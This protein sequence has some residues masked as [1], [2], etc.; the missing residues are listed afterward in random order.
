M[1]DGLAVALVERR[2]EV[3]DLAG[4]LAV[5][6]AGRLVAE[7]ERRVVDDRA[8]D[9]DALLLAAGEL[10]RV[11]VGAVGEAD[12]LERRIDVLLALGAREAA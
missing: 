12:E 5:E 1:I 9:A 8:R 7:E 2:E 4:R 10:R 6:V 11:V 3:E